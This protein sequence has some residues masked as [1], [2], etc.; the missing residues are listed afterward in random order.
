MAAIGQIETRGLVAAIQAAD[1]MLKAASVEL[2]SKENVGGGY[3]T[4]TVAGDVGAVKAA[5]DAGGEENRRI[6]F[7]KH[8]S[9]PTRRPGKRFSRTLRSQQEEL[10]NSRWV[11]ST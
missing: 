6:G 3:V 7:L 10:V 4:V 8:H 9:A 1:A 5:L 11:Q 2:L